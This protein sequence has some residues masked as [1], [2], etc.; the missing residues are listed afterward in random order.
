MMIQYRSD[1]DDDDQHTL[2]EATVTAAHVKFVT[3]LNYSNCVLSYFHIHFHRVYCAHYGCP[4][5]ET[6]PICLREDKQ[7]FLSFSVRI[8]AAVLQIQFHSEWLE[9]T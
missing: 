7:R 3:D 5:R 4:R 1:D 9:V 2:T 6:G 8:T